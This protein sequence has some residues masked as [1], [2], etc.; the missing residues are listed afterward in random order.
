MELAAEAILGFIPCMS[1]RKPRLK[2]LVNES[3][4]G[5]VVLRDNVVCVVL[6]CEPIQNK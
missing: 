1:S 6:F 4:A 5:Q 2:R 3:L